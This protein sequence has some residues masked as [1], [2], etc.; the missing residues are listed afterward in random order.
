MLQ[1]WGMG[2]GDLL[3][4]DRQ[5][6]DRIGALHAQCGRI[7]VHRADETPGE[8]LHGFAVFPGTLD[9]LVIDV[10]DVAHIGH[11]IT[12]VAQ[13][14][15]HD[16]ENNHHPG[17][18]EVAVV[19]D[20]H[21]AD[22]HADFAGLDGFECLLVPGKG[23]IDFEHFRLLALRSGS[24]QSAFCLAPFPQRRRGTATPSAREG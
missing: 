16:V 6:N 5:G 18:P 7:L 9:D 24:A 11:V 2:G 1:S 13:P 21:A 14:A 19:I 12:R 22:V 23:V 17:V 8:L 3:V 20:R 15:L 4:S 10:G